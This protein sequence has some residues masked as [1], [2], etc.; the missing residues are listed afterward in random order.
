MPI[1][2][3]IK[4]AEPAK[5]R[6]M[7]LIH[8]ER[9][10]LVMPSDELEKF[11]R[12][13]ALLKKGYFGVERFSGPGDMGRDV[14][15]YLTKAKHEGDWHNY[16]CK[17]YGKAVPLG[18]GLGELGKILYF[19]HEGKFT[20]PTKYF[21]VAPKGVVRPLREYISKP[22]QL[23]KVLIDTWDNYCAKTITKTAVVVLTPSLK[24]FIEAWDFSCVSVISVDDML[25]DP[26]GKII[27]AKRFKENPEPAP[28]G[29]VPIDLE[30]REMP[31]VRQLLDAYGERD[32]CAYADHREVKDHDDHGPHLS[33]QRERFFDADAFTRFYRDNTMSEEIDLLRDDIYHGVTDTHT[34]KH[35]DSLA[36]ANAVMS[37]AA[38]IQP[39]GV[40]SRHARVPVK[41]GICHHFA[42]EGKLKWRKK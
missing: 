40:L 17:Q 18:S 15:G 27:M 37:Q 21:F 41:Q 26:A 33:M 29:V 1:L 13:W 12:E 42:N 28:K 7:T 19:A 31:Y 10:I 6:R 39:S 32:S 2:Q 14:V 38:N 23:K 35:D 5:H 34:A 4:L 20:A 25:G 9:H 16:Q 36:R 11:A 22:S 8:P 3:R 30:D 24:T